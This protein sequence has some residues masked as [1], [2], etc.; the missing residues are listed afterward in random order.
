[1]NCASTTMPASRNNW[2]AFLFSAT[3]V[4]L[5]NVEFQLRRG[6]GAQRDMD[7]PGLSVKRQQCLVPQDIRHAGLMPQCIVQ[8]ASDQLLAKLRRTSCG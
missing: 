4:S 2:I 1:M 6:L 7:Q 5:L 3:V 8:P